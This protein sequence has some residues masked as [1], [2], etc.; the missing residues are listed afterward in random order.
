MNK[1]ILEKILRDRHVPEDSCSLNGIRG[2][3]ALCL[4]EEN[5]EWNVVY[6]ERGHIEPIKTFDT[7][8]AACSFIYDELK[9]NYKWDR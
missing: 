3:E 2:Y 9:R 4:V 1:K 8:D 5:S 7:E 6:N